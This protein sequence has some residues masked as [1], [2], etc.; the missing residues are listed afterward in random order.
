MSRSALNSAFD[1]TGP[2]AGTIRV[3]F[4]REPQEDIHRIH[5]AADP[6]SGQVVE[7]GIAQRRS[8]V[9]HRKNVRIPEVDIDIAVRVGQGQVAVVDLLASR[10]QRTGGEKRLRGTGSFRAGFFIA[11]VS[12]DP[13]VGRHPLQGALV[14]N[15]L[16]PR[17]EHFI[18]AG[19]IDVMVRIE[20]RVDLGVR[21]EATP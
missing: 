5:A 21:A 2:Y 9:A 10:C 17:R 4:I 3:C 11:I 1:R 19:L 8:H 16:R 18:V 13:V 6:R 7:R 15:D 20:E 14:R 12:L